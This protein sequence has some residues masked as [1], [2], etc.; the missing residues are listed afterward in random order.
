MNNEQYQ[1]IINEVYER[2]IES[3]IRK[4]GQIILPLSKNRF[5]NR[6]K[7]DEEFSKKWGLKIEERG[8]YLSTGEPVTVIDVYYIPKQKVDY[9]NVTFTILSNEEILENE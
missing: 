5:I 9:L 4:D 1:Q 7:T 6:I 2:F 8:L 3:Y